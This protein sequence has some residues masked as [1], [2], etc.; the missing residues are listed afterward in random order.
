[1]AIV[2]R[3]LAP[4]A[5]GLAPAATAGGD[6]SALGRPVFK[7]GTAPIAFRNARSFMAFKAWM[8]ARS[9]SL[10][11]TCCSKPS[12]RRFSASS[13]W[14]SSLGIVKLSRTSLGFCALAGL[15]TTSAAKTEAGG[16]FFV[17]ASGAFAVRRCGGAGGVLIMAGLIDINGL[18]SLYDFKETVSLQV[19]RCGRPDAAALIR[20]VAGAQAEII[21][22]SR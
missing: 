8:P 16:L 12:A 13:T 17:G 9:N 4:Q 14:Y 1:M 20:A 19:V 7:V 22:M 5:E 21:Q 18:Y 3:H 15:A 2:P 6:Q 10:L 11:R